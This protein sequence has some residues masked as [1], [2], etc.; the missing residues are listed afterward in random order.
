MPWPV[1]NL[2][3]RV[4]RSVASESPNWPKPVI[5]SSRVPFSKRDG[6]AEYPEED[7]EGL[8]RA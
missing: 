5:D 3:A 1:G 6:A 7:E 8:P 4:I 2:C